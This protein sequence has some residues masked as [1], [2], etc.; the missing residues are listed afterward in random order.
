MHTFAL[1]IMFL[2]FKL[3]GTSD[4]EE[5]I[6]SSKISVFLKPQIIFCRNN[7]NGRRIAKSIWLCETKNNSS[8][9]WQQ[10]DLYSSEAA[11]TKPQPWPDCNQ[12]DNKY[13]QIP[14]SK[15]VI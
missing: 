14:D 2:I 7:T 1:Q 8:D 6:K 13:S 15:Y 5:C 9:L 4:Y 12:M 3:P 10:L 11:F